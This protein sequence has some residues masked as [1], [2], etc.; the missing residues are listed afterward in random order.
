M[1]GLDIAIAVA[2]IGAES[3]PAIAAALSR[4]TPAAALSSAVVAV[5]QST[6]SER[7]DSRAGAPT[8]PLRVEALR[9]RDRATSLRALSRPGD[10]RILEDLADS[11]LRDV[12]SE[13]DTSRVALPGSESQR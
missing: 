13:D 3:A 8:H 12:R 5:V 6:A 7:V 4:G 9:L 1:T 11:L 2:R 10:G